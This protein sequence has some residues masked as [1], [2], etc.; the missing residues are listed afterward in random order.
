MSKW[1]VKLR[2]RWKT[3]YVGIH[4]IRQVV[5]HYHCHQQ[6]KSSSNFGSNK[7]ILFN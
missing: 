1:W 4:M 7:Q 2:I 5:Y 6:L 3:I